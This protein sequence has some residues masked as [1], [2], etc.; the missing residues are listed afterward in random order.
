MKL[1]H[2]NKEAILIRAC[3]VAREHYATASYDWHE[4]GY[5]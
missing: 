1:Y 5:A 4:G 2:K 3:G